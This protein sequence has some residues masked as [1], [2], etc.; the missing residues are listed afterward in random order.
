MS[1]GISKLSFRLWDM[2]KC[3]HLS[4]LVQATKL[5]YH[6]NNIYNAVID[7]TNEI[8]ALKMNK[9]WKVYACQFDYCMCQIKVA[10]VKERQQ[11]Y[12]LVNSPFN[13]KH[14][15]MMTWKMGGWY[16]KKWDELKKKK[17]ESEW[18]IWTLCKHK[19]FIMGMLEGIIIEELQEE[20]WN[21]L[22][23]E[24]LPIV[25]LK[26]VVEIIVG[27]LLLFGVVYTNLANVH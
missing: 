25:H 6:C 14:C 13:W 7:I 19:V 26:L 22:L 9:I 2:D 24:V 20:G 23:Q 4:Y 18:R 27:I 3:P 17:L 15:K 8:Y 5:A 21:L 11:Q 10:G 1:L 12:S 16:R